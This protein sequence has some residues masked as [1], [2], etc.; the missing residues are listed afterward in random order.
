M[1]AMEKVDF[2]S[3]AL[4]AIVSALLHQGAV[5]L[6]NFVDTAALADAYAIMLR[7]YEKTDKFY[8]SPDVLSQLGLPKFSD[9][10]FTQRHHDLLGKVF[11]GRDVWIDGNTLSRRVAKVREPPHWLQPTAPHLDAFANELEFTVNFWVP[12]QACGIDAPSLAVVLAQF[13]EIV[14]YTGYQNGAEVWVDPQPF[15]R[16]SRFRPAM[17]ALFRSSDPAMLA[18]MHE[19][20]GDRIRTPAFVPGDAMM[21][22]NYTLH[23]T[24]STPEM[25]KN[26]ENLELRFRTSASLEEILHE[27]GI[28]ARLE[29]VA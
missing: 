26:R 2:R 4:D 12:F 14:A 28:A 15:K 9:V 20:F 18:D 5:L 3:A 1:E 27:H 19:R 7:A 13:D 17:K 25:T 22:S 6:G 21:I 16:L 8:V 29:G 23:F 11:G 24:H 10:L